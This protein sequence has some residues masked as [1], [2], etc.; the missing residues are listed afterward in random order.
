MESN[1]QSH[2]FPLLHWAI[3]VFVCVTLHFQFPQK[4]LYLFKSMIKIKPISFIGQME[5]RQYSNLTFIF[6]FFELFIHDQTRLHS[7][8]SYQGVF[9]EN[10]DLCVPKPKATKPFSHKPLKGSVNQQNGKRNAASIAIPQEQLY[11]HK[12]LTT[13]KKKWFYT[14]H[15]VNLFLK[16]RISWWHH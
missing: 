2:L 16:R 1:H 8:F 11:H 14:W 5:I 13:L 3:M 12:N 4:H 6:N 7:T 9:W 10:N 15:A